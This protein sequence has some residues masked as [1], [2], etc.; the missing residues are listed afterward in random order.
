MK[1]YEAILDE[2]QEWCEKKHGRKSK[3]ARMLGVSPQLV[4]DWF[5]RTSEPMWETGLKIQAF[6]K[7]SDTARRLA[8]KEKK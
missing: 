3:F 1:E 2:L 8:I 6:L 4:N 5:A 7:K